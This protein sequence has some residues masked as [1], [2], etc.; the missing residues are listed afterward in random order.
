MT[1]T[2]KRPSQRERLLEHLQSGKSLM[3]LEAWEQLG[4]LEAPARIS[5]LKSQGYDIKTET[6]TVRNRYGEPVRIASWYM[7]RGAK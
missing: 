5:E 7:A 2:A 6:I 3:R 4:I 1:S